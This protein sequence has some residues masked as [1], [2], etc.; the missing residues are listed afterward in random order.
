MMGELSEMK[1]KFGTL[2]ATPTVVQLVKRAKNTI[3]ANEKHDFIG[4][5]RGK[6]EKH[7]A[8]SENACFIVP[9]FVEGNRAVI[10]ARVKGEKETLH[11]GMGLIGREH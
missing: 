11:G 2:I 6:I 10:I 4:S 9:I 3:T 5:I 1:F 7:F 8:D